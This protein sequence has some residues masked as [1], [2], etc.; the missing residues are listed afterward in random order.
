MA[1]VQVKICPVCT[2]EMPVYM[3]ICG[4]NCMI[5][6]AV[7]AGGTVHCPNNLPINSI[8]ADGSMYEHEHGDHADYKFPVN[9]SFIGTRPE[10][11]DWDD[12]YT[13]ECHALLWTDGCVALTMFECNYALWSLND[14]SFLGGRY[15][16]KNWRLDGLEVI[17]IN[18]YCSKHKIGQ[19]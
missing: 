1:D 3:N 11:P 16:D 2:K 15:N 12:S 14:G 17:K 13:T 7:D 5:R 4:G 19:G 6:S 18:E 8:H 9:V 10:L